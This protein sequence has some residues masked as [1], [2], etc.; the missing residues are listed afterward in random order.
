VKIIVILDASQCGAQ[1][2]LCLLVV[3]ERRWPVAGM[4]RSLTQ[5]QS[6]TPRQRAVDDEVGAAHPAGGRR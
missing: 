6:C 5:D 2:G 4:A 3:V 1:V